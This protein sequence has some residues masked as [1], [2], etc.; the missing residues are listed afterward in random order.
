M[1]GILRSDGVAATEVAAVVDI[2]WAYSLRGGGKVAL[3]SGSMWL[4]IGRF[5][6]RQMGLAVALGRLRGGR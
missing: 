3:P 2:P 6:P 5:G 1:G 4:L